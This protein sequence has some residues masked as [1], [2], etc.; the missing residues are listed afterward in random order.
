MKN[1]INQFKGLSKKKQAILLAILCIIIIMLGILISFLFFKPGSKE[2]NGTD[3]SNNVVENKVSTDEATEMYNNVTKD[4]SGALVFDL[5]EGDKV[6][7]EN[8]NDYSSA[9]KTNDYYSKMIGYTYDK[10][11]N[12][13]IH[14][15]VLKK[16]DNKL[17]DLNDNEVAT[18]SED[19]VKESLNKGTTYEY[20]YKEENDSY[21]LI[22]V[23]LM[24]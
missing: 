7:I 10:D 11:G 21:R 9:C 18:F 14:V 16:V 19:T 13:I 8:I 12:V 24:K 1:V 15:N 20:V 22:E 23:K 17:F 6:D 4:C 5:K 2:N 3:Q